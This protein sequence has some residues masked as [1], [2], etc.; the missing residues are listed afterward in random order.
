MKPDGEAV[1]SGV[2]NAAA[3]IAKAIEGYK[4]IVQK[5]T[6]PV[7]AAKRVGQ[8]IR[9]NTPNDHDL[10]L[11]CNPEFT[12]GGKAVHDLLRPDGIVIGFESERGAKA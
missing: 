12:R 2:E 8:E 6:V 3:R 11:V 7:K 1:L 9:S 5:G 10:G 4:V